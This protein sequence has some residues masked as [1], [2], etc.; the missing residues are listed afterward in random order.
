MEL[1]RRVGLRPDGS[2]WLPERRAAAGSILLK[3][4]VMGF[5]VPPGSGDEELFQ[6][7]SDLF[8]RYREQSR[9]LSEHLCPADRRIQRYIDD[10][11]RREGFPEPV[12][13]PADTFILDQY[14]LARE[15]SL[16][17]DGDSW[18]NE[19]VSSYRLDNG[20]LH[21]PVNDRRTTQGVFHV[22]EGGLPIP[23]DK[24]RVPLP[25]YLH[26]LRAALRPPAEILRLPFTAHWVQP[27][28]T[29]VSLL[30]RPLVC[31]RAQRVT[32]ELRMEVRFFVP[33]GLI[34]NLDF[35]ESIFGNAGD[36]YLPINDAGLDADGWTGHSGCVILAPHLTR[37]RKRAVG[38]PHV[39]RATEAERAAGMCWADEEE[40]YNGGRPFKITSR[41]MRGVM[42][43]I[44]ADNYFGY[45]KKEVKTQIGYSANLFG[46]A[47]EEHAGGALAFAT[48]NLGDRFLPEQVR[49]TSAAH[50]LSEV[51]GLLGERVTVHPSGYATDRIH[52]DVHYMP[53]DM[54]IDIHGQD[55]RWMRDG[56]EQHLKL[57]PG[58][59]YFHP[60][61]YRVRMA[62]HTS[63][64]SW[65]L[66]GT[67]P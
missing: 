66:V 25:T 41:D 62:K 17:M 64:P 55:I 33:G 22:A 59:T 40:L 65:R 63:A 27:V 37:L 21:N 49:V 19:L 28:E 5:H 20:V 10:L 23:A 34:S 53:E 31:P 60:S 14:G 15:L 57:L 36:P 39:S 61:G 29:M 12:R 13:L 35:V 45:C 7:A 43:T 38:L 50:R 8:A 48:F 9:L 44:L 16:P 54:E 3:L 2:V 26:L 32:P 47:E 6:R 30:L 4:A 56:E 46:L 51:L 1:E 11:I 52:P 42:V 67:V 58:R 24:I 18:T